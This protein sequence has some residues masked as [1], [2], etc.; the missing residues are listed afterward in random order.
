[1]STDY[2]GLT[3]NVWPGTWST[4]SN[5]PIALDTE[6]RG[7]LQSISGDSGDRLTDIPGARLTEGMLVYVKTGYTA[8][9]VTRTG[10][11]YYKYK[12]Q[13]GESRSSV[14]GAMPNA[15]ANWE[16][17]TFGSG[18]AGSD[19]ATGATGAMG[20]TG[21][22]GAT[23]VQGATGPAGAGFTVADN[24]GLSYSNNVLSTIYNTLVANQVN[25]VSVGGAAA[26]EAASWKAK[27]LVDVLD[28][29]L[30][31]DLF[32][33]YVIPTIT[34]THT[35]S[36]VYEVGTPVNQTI[37]VTAT[38]NDA[39]PFTYLSINRNNSSILDNNNLGATGAASLENEYG[40]SNPNN[41]NNKYI[42]TYN[43]VSGA[44][45]VDEIVWDASGNY[46]AGNVKKNN[47]GVD[48]SRP[49]EERSAS[50]PQAAGSNF[51][52]SS[53]SVSGIYPY[54]YGVSSTEPTGS[55]VA[56]QISGASAIKQLVNGNGDIAV[57]FDANSEYIWL[58]VHSSY[59]QKQ[60]WYNSGINNGSIGEQ[61]FILSPI[62]Y[63]ITS[64]QGLWAGQT[65]KIYR[66]S[67]ATSTS[68]SIIFKS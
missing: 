2:S 52:S 11:S 18:G 27:S 40:Y 24:K 44:V 8:G 66:S 57:T 61:Q 38:K 32:P 22:M 41:P 67:E 46:S 51:K 31:P 15:E 9:L 33:S 6:L 47:K 42:L 4:G 3:R 25:S 10:D 1:M 48:D 39:G 54:F 53:V 64:P 59:A 28:T 30:F 50:A 13:A 55:S 12:L 43:N 68:G 7:T 65:Y 26:A 19:G 45:T 63:A 62:E 56:A 20:A 49:A 29:I 17:A 23:G 36:G 35:Q 37:T 5:S 21:S 16:V 60:T 58:A 14:T 34:I